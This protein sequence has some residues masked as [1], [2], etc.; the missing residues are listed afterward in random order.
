MSHLCCSCVH[1]LIRLLQSV[2]LVPSASLIAV[3]FIILR[4]PQSFVLNT[5]KCSFKRH[6]KMSEIKSCKRANDN[7]RLIDLSRSCIRAQIIQQ[8]LLL[9]RSWNVIFFHGCHYRDNSSRYYQLGNFWHQKPT[10]RVLRAAVQPVYHLTVVGV[11]STAT[12]V[13]L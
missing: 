6:S 3:I 12:S 9:L 4:I 2:Q 1:P 11:T 5:V 10:P 8:P 13:Q 7:C